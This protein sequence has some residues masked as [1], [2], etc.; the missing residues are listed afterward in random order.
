MQKRVQLPGA[1]KEAV[2]WH[3]LLALSVEWEEKEP[4]ARKTA[5]CFLDKNLQTCALS[6]NQ[7]SAGRADIKNVHNMA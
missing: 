3:G 6:T 5:L 4:Q 7:F 1:I 2:V